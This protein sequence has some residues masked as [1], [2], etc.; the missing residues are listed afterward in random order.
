MR[1]IFKLLLT[2]GGLVSIYLFATGALGT[3]SRDDDNSNCSLV[4][5]REQSSPLTPYKGSA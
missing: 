5:N 3:L 2:I 1:A 4:A